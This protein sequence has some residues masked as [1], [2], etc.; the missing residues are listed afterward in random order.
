MQKG[1]KSTTSNSSPTKINNNNN[2]LRLLTTMEDP[3]YNSIRDENDS[4]DSSDLVL[5][6]FMDK[7]LYTIFLQC[8][9]IGTTT[10]SLA[11][12]ENFKRLLKECLLTEIVYFDGT[13]PVIYCENYPHRKPYDS[14]EYQIHSIVSV[15]SSTKHS[16]TIASS[17]SNLK[18]EKQE[19]IIIT[20]HIQRKFPLSSSHGGSSFRIAIILEV[21]KVINNNTTSTSSSSTTTSNSDLLIMNSL[22]LQEIIYIFS[23][24]FKVLS[25]QG[26]AGTHGKQINYPQYDPINKKREY[27]LKSLSAA[28]TIIRS[29]L[30]VFDPQHTSK[31]EMHSLQ[32]PVT[33][34]ALPITSDTLVSPKGRS[35]KSKDNNKKSNITLEEIAYY[36]VEDYALKHMQNNN[37]SNINTNIDTGFSVPPLL[38]TVS[39]AQ[40]QEKAMNVSTSLST[41]MTSSQRAKGGGPLSNE[42]GSSN[43]NNNLPVLTTKTITA[44]IEAQS[45]PTSVSG[46]SK[47]RTRKGSRMTSGNINEDTEESD[48]TMMTTTT[49]TNKNNDPK[50]EELS[51]SMISIMV[52]KGIDDEEEEIDEES[53]KRPSKYGRS[54]M[55]SLRYTMNSQ[56]Q[57][58][59]A[60]TAA[61]AMLLSNTI[62]SLPLTLDNQGKGTTTLPFLRSISDSYNIP[63]DHLSTAYPP[64]ALF[65]N[66]SPIG[67]VTNP[68][69]SNEGMTDQLAPTL[70]FSPV[71]LAMTN[72]NIPPTELGP[73]SSS[74]MIG[75]RPGT[76]NPLLSMTASN[77]T[78]TD[79]NNNNNIEP[80]NNGQNTNLPMLS[81]SLSF[82]T[83]VSPLLRGFPSN[84][85]N[86]NTTCNSN[87]NN[88][89]F[90]IDLN[91]TSSMNMGITPNPITLGNTPSM[92][93]T[94]LSPSAT[95]PGGS[96]I[97][98][99]NNQKLPNNSNNND[100][101]LSS[102]IYN[103]NEI[104]KPI[105]TPIIR[106][107]GDIE[108]R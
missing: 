73:T 100:L 68:Y 23:N 74:Y 53:M 86:T 31:E 69:M 3:F 48:T 82:N 80:M 52:P 81:S 51:K 83:A 89:N 18:E 20:I 32:I 66:A 56:Q 77:M 33:D 103:T 11:I 10:N 96:Y 34:I 15:P 38:S 14:L 24:P 4:L 105:S 41:P 37:T 101:V 13:Q 64:A 22:Q 16:T 43:T 102:D 65:S 45:T 6:L 40:Q 28:T 79:H 76:D 54:T 17:S 62:H 90:S 29:Q 44:T 7:S 50:N 67:T 19:G 94:S 95:P 39:K 1:K 57:L 42:K 46:S 49:I 30:E 59:A 75:F 88:N 36:V 84:I 5:E 99:I 93:E 63:H 97:N 35:S 78:M 71:M 108:T 91:T 106:G 21:P 9:D 70:S 72:S 12:E 104:N 27:I 55:N 26:K 61:S 60:A 8:L 87:I 92:L 47:K 58:N 85:D 25:K 107:D 2:F 98:P